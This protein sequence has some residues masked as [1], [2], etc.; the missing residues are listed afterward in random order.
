MVAP[1]G[2]LCASVITEKRSSAGRRWL[3]IDAG[4][5]DLIRPALYA[6]KHRIDD[7]DGGPPDTRATSKGGARMWRVVG[8]VCESSDDFGDHP[9][10]GTPTRVVIRDAGAYGF[11]MASQYNGRA[12]P[13]EVF[14]S[15]GRIAGISRPRD[16]DAWVAERLA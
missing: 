6:A 5:N 2:V 7:L 10:A 13:V 15:G 11:T 16:V 4:M 1:H 8:P 14:L 9:F 12:L 3:V